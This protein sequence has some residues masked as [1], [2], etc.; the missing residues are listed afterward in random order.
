V[1]RSKIVALW[2]GKD[3]PWHVALAEVDVGGAESPQPG[4]DPVG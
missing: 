2:I 3:R 4:I 1:R